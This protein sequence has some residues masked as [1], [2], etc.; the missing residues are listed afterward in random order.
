MAKFCCAIRPPCGTKEPPPAEASSCLNTDFIPDIRR[1]QQLVF[2]LRHNVVQLRHKS[3]FVV[4]LD[5]F[6]TKIPGGPKYTRR[7]SSSNDWPKCIVYF[8]E[9]NNFALCLIFFVLVLNTFWLP[10]PLSQ[11][12]WNKINLQKK[13]MKII[14]KKVNLV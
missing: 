13:S 6:Q 3:H 4:Q 9:P 12:I 8:G 10:E 5:C 14:R 1:L 2:L 11:L 7:W